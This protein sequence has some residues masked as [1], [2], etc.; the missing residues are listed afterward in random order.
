MSSAQ[1]VRVQPNKYKIHDYNN[2]NL[3]NS[4]TCSLVLIR[5]NSIIHAE[6]LSTELTFSVSALS[7]KPSPGTGA[8][9]SWC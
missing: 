3:C 4:H 5:H 6:H 9:T 7:T 1:H 2:V 8:S